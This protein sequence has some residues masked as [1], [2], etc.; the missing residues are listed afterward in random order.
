MLPLH[1][2]LHQIESQFQGQVLKIEF[3]DDG[4]LFIYKIRIL[5]AHGYLLKLK[6]NALTGEVLTVKQRGHKQ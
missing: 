4:G 3:E 1:S 6:V 5:Q 2:V